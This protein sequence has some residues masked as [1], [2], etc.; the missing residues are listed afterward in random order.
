[1]KISINEAVLGEDARWHGVDDVNHQYLAELWGS[2]AAV[3]AQHGIKGKTNRSGF[4]VADAVMVRID[5]KRLPLE[6][7]LNAPFTRQY[8][9]VAAIHQHALGGELL[10]AFE[11]PCPVTDAKAFVRIMAGLETLYVGA[12]RH[13]SALEPF[14]LRAKGEA[15]ALGSKLDAKAVKWLDTLGLETKERLRTD[16]AFIRSRHQVDRSTV[17]VLADGDE[18][19]LERLPHGMPVF[20]PVHIDHSPR[21]VVHWYQDGTPGIQCDHCL[22]TYAAPNTHR[23]YDF[24]H[25]DR[26]VSGLA[27]NQ[28][29]AMNSLVESDGSDVLRYSAQ[30]LP[31]QALVDA[32]MRPVA[33]AQPVHPRKPMVLVR[34]SASNA[35]VLRWAPERDI[36]TRFECVNGI[37]FVKS[38]KGTNKTGI[39]EAFVAQCKKDQ[40]RVLLIGHRRSLLQAEAERLNMDC[41]FVVDG[42]NQ[43][44]PVD[45][46]NAHLDAESTDDVEDRPQPEPSGKGA[47]E[48]AR[49]R[50]VEPTRHYAV[51]LDSLVELDTSN[52]DHRYD[53]V[54]IDESEQVFTHLV[55][56]TLKDRRRK[57]FSTLRYYLRKAR[58]VVVLDADLNMITMDTIFEI[59]HDRPETPTQ[60]IVN[61]PNLQHGETKLYGS[62]GHLV[63][64]LADRVR[65]GKKIYVTTNSKSKAYELEKLVG[66]NAPQSKVAV[67]TS[68]NTQTKDVQGMLANIRDQFEHHLDV[69][70]ASP[71]IG[72]GIDISY[73]DANG[74]PRIVVDCVFGVFEGNIVTHFDI[75][76][77]L[78]RVRHPGEVHVWVDVRPM[79]YETDIGCIKRELEVS[80]RRTEH[81]LRIDDDD[82][83]TV[84]F[85]DFGLVNIWARVLAASRGSKNHLASLFTALREHD[86]WHPIETPVDKVESKV[87]TAAMCAAKEARLNE[88][89]QHILAAVQIEE[90]EAKALQ[91]R[92]KRGAGLTESERW[93]LERYQ[94]E[95][96][97]DDEISAELVKLDE[98]GR[99]RQAVMRLECLTS[100]QTWLANRDSRETIKLV[101]DT[102]GLVAFDRHCYLVQR[103]ILEV[104]FTTAGIF[105]AEAREFRP[106]VAVANS[107]LLKFMAAVSAH[108]KQIEA[109]FGVTLNADSQNNPFGQLKSLLRLVG[110]ETVQVEIVQKYGKKTRRYA[111]DGDRLDVLVGAVARRD[112]RYKRDDVVPD[113]RLED[114]V[115]VIAAKKL[116]AHIAKIQVGRG[117]VAA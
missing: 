19:I 113:G 2:G 79:N 73:R 47:Q 81:F 108:A 35:P 74:N 91:D 61:Q 107:D 54:I 80:L 98:C 32:V 4:G 14:A 22:R 20:C 23:E 70:I 10:L 24:G 72:T 15:L 66:E 97:Y 77:Q 38:P 63:Q 34:N 116:R 39:L 94:I 33:N 95:R 82:G 117:R 67:V 45:T 26:V 62:R 1:M 16:G 106:E 85:D 78:M 17:M 64:I 57:V 49:Y 44:V 84:C 100:N 101:D 51:C 55:G 115:E 99:T 90:G 76:Q 30:F 28:E 12:S 111:V 37:T 65:Q 7:A 50:F 96:F 60:F 6:V 103:E 48:S 105:D 8:A 89:E 18:V 56:K 59:F 52:K 21:A 9:S 83:R 31:A 114:R 58:H 40:L 112:A 88:R 46:T 3:A 87:G 29:S 104:L 27:T 5:L 69:L 68:D 36:A 43:A 41:Y 71:A 75:D 93:A 110:L 53:V 109:I 11:L 102:R 13:K 86:G 92:D 42:D 25:F